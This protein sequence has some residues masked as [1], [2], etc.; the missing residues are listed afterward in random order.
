MHIYT[1]VLTH[2]DIDTVNTSISM[3]DTSG[4]IVLE[5]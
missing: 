5:H 4:S 3:E 2:T 1:H